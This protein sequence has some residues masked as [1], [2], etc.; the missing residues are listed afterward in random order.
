M[1]PQVNQ[2]NRRTTEGNINTDEL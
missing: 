2:T 1:A